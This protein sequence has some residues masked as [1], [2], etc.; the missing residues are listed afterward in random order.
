M[1]IVVQIKLIPSAIQIGAAKM[2]HR[3]H[4]LPEQHY[5]KQ[6]LGA[7]ERMAD[8]T[9]HDFIHTN[10]KTEHCS[11]YKLRQK[12]DLNQGNLSMMIAGRRK[13]VGGWKLNQ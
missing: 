2:V 8:S 1:D 9:V 6:I 10:G 12:Y 5:L 11:A 13:S 3:C 7:G 4:C